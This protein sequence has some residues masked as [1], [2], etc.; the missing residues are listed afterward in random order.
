MAPEN[1]HLCRSPRRDVP[2]GNPVED[3]LAAGA[4]GP[5]GASTQGSLSPAPEAPQEPSPAP[6]QPT[7]DLFK[8][9]MKAFLESPKTGA[10]G[11]TEPCERF[12]KARLPDL[13]LGKLHMDCYHF[14]Q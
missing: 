5:A 10:Q 9:F 13:Y 4:Q 14:C 12:L 7:E 8:Q 1:S 3:E 6:G 2:P 11:P